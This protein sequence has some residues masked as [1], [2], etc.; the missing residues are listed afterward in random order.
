MLSWAA[1]ACQSLFFSSGT[2]APW[3]NNSLIL[4]LF[5]LS[6]LFIA[7]CCAIWPKIKSLFSLRH[8]PIS[9][10][11]N[12]FSPGNSFF[13]LSNYFVDLN[14]FST[15]GYAIICRWTLCSTSFYIVSTYFESS[16]IFLLCW[17]L[18]IRRMKKK[19]KKNQDIYIYFFLV[20]YKGHGRGSRHD[21]P[22]H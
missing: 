7:T 13:L 21:W 5:L 6:Y 9:I 18:Y 3:C 10:I 1:S 15:E 16:W 14:W 11:V 19:K 4:N 12:I 22:S 2:M 20:R 17:Y 8:E